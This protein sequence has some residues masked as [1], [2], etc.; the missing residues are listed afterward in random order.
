MV[1]FI[2]FLPDIFFQLL[3]VIVVVL[4]TGKHIQ[5]FRHRNID[6][7]MN[8]V[9]NCVLSYGETQYKR[10]HFLSIILV[11]TS[12]IIIELFDLSVLKEWEFIIIY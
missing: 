7:I 1:P 6:E 9:E 4:N 2:Q 5:I 10:F 3:F 12:Y 8:N 11:Q